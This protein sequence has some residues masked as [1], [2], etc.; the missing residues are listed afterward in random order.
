MIA[1]ENKISDTLQKYYDKVFQDGKLVN[2]HIGMW[3]MSAGLMEEDI[4]LDN[5]LP[6]NIDLGKKMLIQKAVYKKFKNL[7]SRIRRYLYDNSFEFPLLSQAHFVP[8]SRYLEVYDGLS[9]LKADY[10][11]AADEFILNYDK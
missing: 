5:K 4:L 10:M 1:S 6:E 2:V 11:A 7:E 3:G 9:K 8:K